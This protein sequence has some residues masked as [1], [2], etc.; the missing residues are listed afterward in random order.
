MLDA[1]C[2][3]AVKASFALSITFATTSSLPSN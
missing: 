3:S 1:L 2:P